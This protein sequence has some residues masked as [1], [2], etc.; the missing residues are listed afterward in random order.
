MRGVLR[1]YPGGVS[2]GVANQ[3]KW[4]GVLRFGTG[5]E[6]QFPVRFH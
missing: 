4:P 1:K 3:P 6:G 5:D 2:L